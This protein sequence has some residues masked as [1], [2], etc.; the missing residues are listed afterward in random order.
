MGRLS[1]MKKTRTLVVPFIASLL[2]VPL[3]NCESGDSDSTTNGSADDK[4]DKG[5]TGGKTT[6]TGSDPG[7]TTGNDKDNDKG[8]KPDGNTGD[9]TGGGNGDVNNPSEGPLDCSTIKATG[10]KEGDVA[11]NV[12]LK[13]ASG[14]TVNLH[15]YC[16][17]IVYVMAGAAY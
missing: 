2:A 17:D 6:P 5:N 13:D 4:G 12:S 10:I 7:T 16:N 8:S 15:D 9:N 3:S 11:P 14:R 1:A